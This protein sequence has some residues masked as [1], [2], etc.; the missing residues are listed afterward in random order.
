MRYCYRNQRKRRPTMWRPGR[1]QACLLSTG[2][3]ADE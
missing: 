3:K 2:A 1:V